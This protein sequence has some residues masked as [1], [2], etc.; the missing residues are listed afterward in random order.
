[1]VAM[2]AEGAS[3]VA[4]SYKR[5]SLTQRTKVGMRP[6]TGPAGPAFFDLVFTSSD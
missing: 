3:L 4:H 2:L 1:M 6:K 5:K